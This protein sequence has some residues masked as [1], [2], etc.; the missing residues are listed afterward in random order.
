MLIQI[1]WTKSWDKIDLLRLYLPTLSQWN[2]Y[3]K[4]PGV[5]YRIMHLVHLR[6]IPT[7]I[8]IISIYEK[9]CINKTKYLLL[10]YLLTQQL[11]PRVVKITLQFPL[12]TDP[13]Q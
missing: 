4:L 2:I 9:I 5:E 13:C 7:K 11:P 3:V 10:S 12:L 8:I 6:L 1:H